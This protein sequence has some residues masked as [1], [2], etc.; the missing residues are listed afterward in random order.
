[1]YVALAIIISTLAIFSAVVGFS[2]E[3]A[4]A[5]ANMTIAPIDIT[6][7]NMTGTNMA[8]AGESNMTA[9]GTE[10]DDDNTTK[11]SVSKLAVSDPG[12]SGPK[13]PVK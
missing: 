10:G 9:A 12:A 13:K 6:G 11:G 1:M 4:G 5:Q 2:I 3:Q 7:E 8:A